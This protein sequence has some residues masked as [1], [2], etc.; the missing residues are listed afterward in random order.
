[1]AKHKPTPKHTKSIMLVASFLVI[2]AAI[3]LANTFTGITGA[4]TAD[5][6]FNNELLTTYKDTFNEK[7]D[8]LPDVVFTFFGEEVVN[9]YLTDIEVTLYAVLQDDELVEL[10]EG[11]Q[12]NPTI[13]IETTYDTV[14]ALQYKEITLQEAIDDELITFS[15]DSFIKQ[16]ELSLVLGAIDIYEVFQ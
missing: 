9:I 11:E 12:E 2:L 10:E 6:Y 1:M 15:S 4:V 3:C 7:A 14:T 13:R 16:A 8:G 5:D